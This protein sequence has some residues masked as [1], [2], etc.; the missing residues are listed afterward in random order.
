MAVLQTQPP[1]APIT[2]KALSQRLE[3]S[4]DDVLA[5]SEGLQQ[6]RPGD[7]QLITI[8]KMI[9]SDGEEDLYLSRVPLTLNDE[10]ETR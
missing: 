2:V 7:E 8:V 5:A 4:A 6:R 3:C 1:G 10:P 9:N